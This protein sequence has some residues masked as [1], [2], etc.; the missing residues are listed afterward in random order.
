MT[1]IVMRNVPTMQDSSRATRTLRLWEVTEL[2]F[3]PQANP[4]VQVFCG[5]S[6]DH[7]GVYLS[8]FTAEEAN[9]WSLKDLLRSHA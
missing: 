5:V 8:H 6:H 7:F 4:N 1:A 9:T 2:A 3:C